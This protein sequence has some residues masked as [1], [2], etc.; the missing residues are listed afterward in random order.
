M[1][2]MTEQ[3]HPESTR[4]QPFLAKFLTLAPGQRLKFE[5]VRR[6]IAGQES[7]KAVLLT[8]I[9]QNEASEDILAESFLATKEVVRLTKNWSLGQNDNPPEDE[10]SRL[11]S[12]NLG[13][14][15]LLNLLD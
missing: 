15:T 13:L 11:V 8:K 10:M 7:I 4:N 14:I 12:I 5:V 2:T 1:A 9:G 3:I 6:S